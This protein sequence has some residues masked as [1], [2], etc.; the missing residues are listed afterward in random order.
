MGHLFRIAIGVLALLGTST[1]SMAERLCAIDGSGILALGKGW[2]SI[3]WSYSSADGGVSYLWLNKCKQLSSRLKRNPKLDYWTQ[4]QGDDPA[5]WPRYCDNIG[6]GWASGTG[7]AIGNW[8]GKAYVLGGMRYE[9]D[10]CKMK[11]YKAWQ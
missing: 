11:Q 4:S 7:N 2:A 6:L 10:A 1:S 8:E 9:P 3:T 5:N